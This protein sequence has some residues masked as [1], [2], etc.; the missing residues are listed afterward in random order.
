MAP[1]IAARRNVRPSVAGLG[2][3]VAGAA[4]AEATVKGGGNGG[5]PSGAAPG[6]RDFNRATGRIY[7]VEQLLARLQESYDAR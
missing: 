1:N 7:T 3:V 4:S 6:G 5:G 2:S